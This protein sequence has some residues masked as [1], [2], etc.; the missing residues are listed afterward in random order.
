MNYIIKKASSF[1]V[2]EQ[3]LRGISGIPQDWAIEKYIYVDNIPEGFELISEEDLVIL[4]ENNQ[5][6][7]DAWLQSLRPIINPISPIQSVSILSQPDH[8]PFA[9]KNITVNGILKK[10]YKRLCGIQQEL[11]IGENIILYTIPYAWVK[12]TGIELIGGENLDKA[13]LYVLDSTTGNYSGVP[14]YTLNQFGSNVN[15]SKDFHNV[16]SNFDADLY[17]GMQIKIV[18]IS[19]SAKTVGLNIDLIEVK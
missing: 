1:T 6:A 13:S 15:V 17:I 4:L 7:Y 8:S 5:S 10:F 11:S 18:Y 12:M 9:A 19:L 16:S 14:N 2:E 3:S